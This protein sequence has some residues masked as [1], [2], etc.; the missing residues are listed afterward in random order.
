M[1]A[2]KA[3][4]DWEGDGERERGMAVRRGWFCGELCVVPLNEWAEQG[5]LHGLRRD[6]VV[7]HWEYGAVRECEIPERTGDS[8]DASSRSNQSFQIG[9]LCFPLFVQVLA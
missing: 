7:N 2:F 5:P 4:R 9:C 1:G 8:W 3:G 6:L